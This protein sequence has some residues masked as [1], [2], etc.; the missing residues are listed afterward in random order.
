MVLHKI[1]YAERGL[2]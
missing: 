1:K 2:Q